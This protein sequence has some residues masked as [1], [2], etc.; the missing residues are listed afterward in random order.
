MMADPSASERAY[1][2]LKNDILSGAL[3]AGPLD[4]RLLGDKLKMS[5]TPVREALAR[6]SAERLVR[7]APHQG[8]AV[9]TLSGR[10]LENLYDFAGS[11]VDMAIERCSTGLRLGAQPPLARPPHR[12]YAEGMSLLV[13]EMASAQGN[14]ELR[15]HL[16]ALDDRLQPARRCEPGVFPDC[17]D[18]LAALS[19]SWER[20]KLPELRRLFR[21]HF[22]S[23][24]DR[25]DALV[26]LLAAQAGD[27]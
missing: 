2:R 22:M 12:T 7:L 23:R 14:L 13:K 16:L 3:T 15:D 8:Y 27:G 24:V 25:A 20:K 9:A 11:L 26:R 17:E 4:L 6:L 5:V 19:G 1:V 18:E 10:R 21:E